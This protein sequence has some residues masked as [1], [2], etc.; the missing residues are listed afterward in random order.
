MQLPTQ[1]SLW[2]DDPVT[3]A[4]V[5]FLDRTI[6]TKT[7]QLFSARKSHPDQLPDFVADLELATA[8]RSTILEGRFFN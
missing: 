2:L 1:H 3:I 5:G 6:Q 4:L 7:Q 8:L